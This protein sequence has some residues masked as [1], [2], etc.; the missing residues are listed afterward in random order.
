MYF[1]NIYLFF[2][3]FSKKYKLNTIK[4]LININKK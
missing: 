2:I 1:L 3:Y 4:H